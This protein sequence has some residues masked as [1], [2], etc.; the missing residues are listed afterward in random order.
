MKLVKTY[1][2]QMMTVIYRSRKTVV[3]SSLEVIYNASRFQ[4]RK[5]N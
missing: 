1:N 5:I 4:L 2:K 3:T